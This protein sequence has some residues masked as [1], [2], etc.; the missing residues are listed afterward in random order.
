MDKIFQTLSVFNNVTLTK[1]QWT[2]IMT[3]AGINLNSYL[4]KAFCTVILE[5]NKWS[6]T[7]RGLSME[8]L[9]EVYTE[10]SS[11]MRKNNQKAYDKKKQKEWEEKAREAARKRE[12][13]KKAKK[14]ALS[15]NRPMVF[16]PDGTVAPLEEYTPCK[17]LD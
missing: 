6:F 14:Q 9:K 17:W 10:Y 1:S 11:L 4:W 15:L 7:L 3:A 2:I 13:E 12:A 5:K 8:T 16:N